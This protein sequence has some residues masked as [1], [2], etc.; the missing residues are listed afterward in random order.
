MAIAV[1]LGRVCHARRMELRYWKQS[2][3]TPEAFN[4]LLASL[5]PDRERAGEKYEEIRRGLVCLFEWRGAP[6]P[7]E[8]ADETINRVA[9]KLDEGN[10]VADPFTY[11]YGVARLVLL[12]AYK[13]REKERAALTQLP[14]PTQPALEE[15][16]APALRFDCLEQC[17]DELP[18]ESRDFLTTYYQG[19]KRAKIDN[20]QRLADGLRIPLN[21][22][23]LRARR[24][25]EKLEVCVDGCVNRSPSRRV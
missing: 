7:D 6:F 20:R 14:P 4:K 16:T 19:E 1:L 11:V 21:A 12:E 17:L 15:E 10:Q 5:D 25:R 13:L 23:R 9:R 2:G 22:L 18:R 8:H 24:A 3:L